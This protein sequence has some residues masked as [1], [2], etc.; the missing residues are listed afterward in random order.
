[1]ARKRLEQKWHTSE[2]NNAGSGDESDV[3]IDIN[4]IG[5]RQYVDLYG[6]GQEEA[7]DLPLPST[8]FSSDNDEIS[9]NNNLS[10]HASNNEFFPTPY[11]SLAKINS[12][13]STHSSKG[14]PVQSTQSSTK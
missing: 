4:D 6:Q 1:M 10:A 13:Q 9:D 8:H 5:I 2:Q 14:I 3:L 11:E 7:D 12:L